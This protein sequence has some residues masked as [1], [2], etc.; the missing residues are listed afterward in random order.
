MDFSFGHFPVDLILFALVAAFLALRLRSVLGRRVGIQ[1]APMPVPPRPDAAGK[2]IDGKAAQPEQ[3]ADYDIP[4]PGTRVGQLLADIHTQDPTFSPQ[5]FLSGVQT[6]FRQVVKAF[7]EGDRTTLQARLTPAVYQS[8]DAAITARDAAGEKQR[9]EIRAIRSL[10]IE[11]VRLTPL[12]VGTG[13]SVDVRIVSDQISLVLGSDGQPVSGMDA[14]T[15]FS[16]LWT[17][18]R[19]LGAGGSSWRLASARSA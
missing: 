14:V 6:A 10:G 5:Q 16:D 13:A 1:P 18:E 11:D 4:T 8:F 12:A 9:T 2:V 17:F 15:E 19:L 3:A 7:A